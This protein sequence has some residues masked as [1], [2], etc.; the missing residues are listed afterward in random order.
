MTPPEAPP[1]GAVPGAP[2]EAASG[3]APGARVTAPGDPF[4]RAP[5][6][7]PEP[8]PGVPCASPATSHPSGSTPDPALGPAPAPVPALGPDPARGPAPHHGGAASTR[9]RPSLT[10]ALRASLPPARR[11][12]RQGNPLRMLVSAAPWRATG[13]LAGYVVTGSVFFAVATA[14][15]VVGIVLG[16]LTVTLALTIGSV[17]VVRCCAQVERGRAAL[18]DAPIP[19]AYQEVTE[20]GLVGHL[21]A[22]CTDPV[23]YRDCCYLILLHPFLLLLDALTLL[24]W[25]PLLAGVCLP[26]WFWAV[27]PRQA[28]GTVA[29]GVRLG[30]SD[31]TGPG[32]WIDTWPAALTA[33]AVFLVLAAYASYAVVAAARLHLAVAHTLLR[34]PPDPLAEAKQ[35]LAAPGPLHL[36]PARPV[37]GPAADE[38]HRT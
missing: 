15:V 26:L 23:F 6:A 17:W 31:G 1:P 20:P 4:V 14:A 37:A 19:Y 18:V 8:A 9:A 34:P 21:K 22:R 3:A 28:D 35:V 11:L 12:P 36:T 10:T 5:E 13:Y 2:A 30:R 25:L 27:E 24:V 16:Q 33:S 7:L 29:H 38:G 32:I